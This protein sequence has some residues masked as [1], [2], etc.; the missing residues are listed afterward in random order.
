MKRAVKTKQMHAHTLTSSRD[1]SIWLKSRKIAEKKNENCVFTKMLWDRRMIC[2][3][4]KLVQS[5]HSTFDCMQKLKS[6]FFFLSFQ[7]PQSRTPHVSHT[8]GHISLIV[9][10]CTCWRW[11][12]IYMVNMFSIR[13]KRQCHRFYFSFLFSSFHFSFSICA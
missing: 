5:M 6:V 11:H 1:A 13:I 12:S 4:A 10:R 8:L 7:W 3:V 2:L 9:D